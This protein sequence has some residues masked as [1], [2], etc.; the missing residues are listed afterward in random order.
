M[1]GQIGKLMPRSK[2]ELTQAPVEV[3]MPDSGMFVL[4]SK[5][6]T[7]FRMEFETRDFWKPTLVSG[8]AGTLDDQ[9]TDKLTMKSSIPAMTTASPIGIPSATSVIFLY[10]P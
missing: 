2:D 4:S 1:L 5:H 3:Q 8:G 10:L 9:M 7:H 6:G